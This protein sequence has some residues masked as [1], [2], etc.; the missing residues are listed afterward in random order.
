MD[1]IG[2]D[3]GGIDDDFGMKGIVFRL[4][5]PPAGGVSVYFFYP[6][7]KK[8]GRTVRTGVFCQCNGEEKG[9]EDG[10]GGRKEAGRNL[11]R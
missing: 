10:G 9:T 1:L 8:E 5:D 11:V 3:A 4:N 7:I 2:I 6:R